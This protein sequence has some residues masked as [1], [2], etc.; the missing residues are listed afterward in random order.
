MSSP[1]YYSPST[2]VYLWGYIDVVRYK[3][4]I[5]IFAVGELLFFIPI[6]VLWG[7]GLIPSVAAPWQYCAIYFIVF[8]PIWLVNVFMSDS[9]SSALFV[10]A[11]FANAFVF[12]VSTFVVALIWYDLIECWIGALPTSCR[13][14]Q[15]WDILCLIFASVLWICAL[16]EFIAYLSIIGRIRQT[17][18]ARTLVLH[19]V[20]S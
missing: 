9:R 16:F 11:F 3:F 14:T 10:F 7:L 15:L 5:L 19:K 18:S 12:A 6:A 17:N 4:Q 1:Y 20:T 8:I 2:V 13:D